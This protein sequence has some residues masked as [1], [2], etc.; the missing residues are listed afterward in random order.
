MESIAQRIYVTYRAG[1]PIGKSL[2]AEKGRETIITSWNLGERTGKSVAADEFH[3][4][5]LSL[6][7]EVE[8]APIKK[9]CHKRAV[10]GVKK[11]G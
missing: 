10:T 3:R 2:V 9:V 8:R 4:F 1:N 6:T 7:G 5:I 11:K